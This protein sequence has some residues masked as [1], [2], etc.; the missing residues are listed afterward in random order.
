[1]VNESFDLVTSGGFIGGVVALVTSIG[2]YL[3]RE[4][5]ESARS[6]NTIAANNASTH[7]YEAQAT[8]IAAVRARLSD[9]ETAYV[10]QAAQIA[11]LLKKV[12]EL[13]ARIYGASIHQSN[14]ILCEPCM[15]KNGRVLEALNKS[16]HFG[17]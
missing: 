11:E 14:L 5:V 6:N 9:I 15:E 4:R 13:E 2:W 10:S 3:R 8:E 7:T 17:E 1:M 16:L 12:A